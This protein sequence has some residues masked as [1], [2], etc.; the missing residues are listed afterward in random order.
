MQFARELDR[1]QAD[2][3]V[4]MYVNDRTLDYGPE[5]RRA[6]QL[7]LDRAFEAG[8]IPAAIEVEFVG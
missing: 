2:R 4:G 5:G 1:G 7:L 6:V 3:F 8:I